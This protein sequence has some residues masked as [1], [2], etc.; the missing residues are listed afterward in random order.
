MSV[1]EACKQ[2]ERKV[3]VLVSDFEAFICRALIQIRPIWLLWLPLRQIV[4]VCGSTGLNTRP[5]PCFY[6]SFAMMQNTWGKFPE[7]DTAPV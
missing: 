1:L 7:D 6:K 2:V 3:S 4:N 5:Q